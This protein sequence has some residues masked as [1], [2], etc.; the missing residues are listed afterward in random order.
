MD[1]TLIKQVAQGTGLS[2]DRIKDFIDKW[3]IE[4]GRSPQNLSFEDFRA[5]LVELIQDLFSE[6]ADG[7]NA[8]IRTS[9]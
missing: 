1:E 9:R 6:V 2:E 4:T 3:V 8:F 5:V 7:K